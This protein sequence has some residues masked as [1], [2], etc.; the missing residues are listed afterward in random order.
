MKK[1][2]VMFSGNG[3]DFQAL[4]DGEARGAFDGKI[5]VAVTSNGSAYGIERAKKAGIDCYVRRKADFESDVARDESVREIFEKYEVEL[6]VLAGY[7]G[8]LTAPL[9]DR[10]K[11]AII[12]I[13]PA[14]LPKFGGKGMYG[15]HVH[16]AVI[17]AGEKK[18]GATVH[19]SDGGIDTGAIILQRSLDV[20]PSDTPESLQKR[21]LEEIEHPLLVEAVA[22]LCASEAK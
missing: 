15:L 11:G 16:E 6:I 14:L 19:Y 2:A 9:L 22:L 3:T 12:N 7:L 10:Y 21:I 17:A 5:V 8:I 13:H 4:I 20:L 18:S 1:I